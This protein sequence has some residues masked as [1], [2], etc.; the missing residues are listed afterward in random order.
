MTLEPSDRL[1][2]Q[3]PP[4]CATQEDHDLAFR[5]LLRWHIRGKLPE[6]LDGTG[7]P[8]QDYVDILGVKR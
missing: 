4:P 1:T 2:T 5:H 6:V 3:L 7:D 8:V